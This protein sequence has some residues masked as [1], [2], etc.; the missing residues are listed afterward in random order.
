MT[1][2]NTDENTT[3]HVKLTEG[4]ISQA[5]DQLGDNSAPGPYG[6]P[7]IFLKKTKQVLLSKRQSLH[8]SS[9]ADVHKM[10]Y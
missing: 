2:L 10:V 1:R 6:I 9:T 3:T 4:D 8:E 7:T 5:V